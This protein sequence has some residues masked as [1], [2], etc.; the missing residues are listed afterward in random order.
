MSAVI[1]LFILTVI[2]FVQRGGGAVQSH[3]V[4]IRGSPTAERLIC[5]QILCRLCRPALVRTN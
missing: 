1:M 3:Q 2:L 4:D 5:Q